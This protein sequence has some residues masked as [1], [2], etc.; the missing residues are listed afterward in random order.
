MMIF[1]Y[2]ATCPVLRRCGLNVK[3]LAYAAARIT[4]YYVGCRYVNSAAVAYQISA[5][6]GH[7]IGSMT[8]TQ[9]ECSTGSVGV[10]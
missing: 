1:I 5:N 10:P 7:R 3:S 2:N 8:C 6:Y 9:T 4:K